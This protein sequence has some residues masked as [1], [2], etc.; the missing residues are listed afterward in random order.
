[1]A[2]LG[3]IAILREPE[4]RLLPLPSETGLGEDVP[5]RGLGPHRLGD[6]VRREPDGQRDWARARPM[7]SS[8][9]STL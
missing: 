7:T 9:A 4:R 2:R 1:M 5:A 3:E 6:G 8:Y